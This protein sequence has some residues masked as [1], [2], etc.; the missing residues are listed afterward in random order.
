MQTLMLCVP[1]EES[2]WAAAPKKPTQAEWSADECA[3]LKK[4][5]ALD[6]LTT[7]EPPEAFVWRTMQIQSLAPRMRSLFML[8]FAL[9][10]QL[11]EQLT[12]LSALKQS[13]DQLIASAADH[14]G[15]IGAVAGRALNLGNA[16]NFR[17][18]A[19]NKAAGFAL[20]GLLEL[21]KYPLP[22]SAPQALQGL[23]LLHY[24][25]AHILESLPLPAGDFPNETMAR[26]AS[27]RTYMERVRRDFS[28][29]LQFNVQAVDL[30][31][32]G[33]QLG[34]L[35]AKLEELHDVMREAEAADD[36]AAEEEDGG[37]AR[38]GEV[39][40]TEVE[41][42]FFSD[43][44]SQEGPHTFAALKKLYTS[45]RLATGGYIW[46]SYLD[47]WVPL[48]DEEGLL[49]E[50]A[51]EEWSDVLTYPASD[52]AAERAARTKKADD[53]WSR[54]YRRA[55]ARAS[56]FQ[57]SHGALPGVV[58]G[59]WTADGVR[60]ALEAAKT[61]MQGAKDGLAAVQVAFGRRFTGGIEA[62]V[63]PVEHL[64]AVKKF[65]PEFER[66]LLAVQTV[67][68]LLRLVAV[69][70]KASLSKGK[71][72]V[73]GAR[74]ARRSIVAPGTGDAGLKAAAQHHAKA[75]ARALLAAWDPTNK[76]HQEL[77]ATKI[78]AIQRGKIDREK[79]REVAIQ[80]AAEEESAEVLEAAASE[81]VRLRTQRS[82]SKLG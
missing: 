42:F 20:E 64:V 79:S 76:G 75:N 81:P 43:G 14:K 54:S 16:L 80:K 38:W 26:A 47:D 78:A 74:V 36:E 22:P 51:R 24:L 5:A 3:D 7:L 44:D 56:V 70:V 25:A 57:G 53:F 29:L 21:S 39:D 40:Y 41:E 66:C 55:L 48:A 49:Q 60:E 77:A 50:L 8:K 23:T 30:H 69:D 15:L 37:R 71:W 1:P 72:V 61:A 27:A 12:T 4:I 63:E 59:R 67:P 18:K 62:P 17:S 35:V 65:V 11:A 82:L 45:G 19:L 31:A 58:E 34:S 46:G 33:E 10:P 6:E 13:C 68:S 28:I 9:E 73:A 32:L 52:S 2:K